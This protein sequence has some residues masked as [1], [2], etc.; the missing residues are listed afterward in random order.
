MERN[1]LLAKVEHRF[2][3]VALQTFQ[4]REAVLVEHLRRPLHDHFDE[5]SVAR[6]CLV[7]AVHDLVQDVL[8]LLL[9][10]SRGRLVE[11]VEAA[12]PVLQIVLVEII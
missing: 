2:L 10:D 7:V 8:L 3:L 4:R 5:V 9:L 12:V 11:V 6:E 1:A